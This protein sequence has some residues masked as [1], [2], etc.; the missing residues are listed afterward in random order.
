M[1]LENESKIK[2]KK[3]FFIENAIEKRDL[4]YHYE[5]IW[6]KRN[7]IWRISQQ[8]A[9]RF[10]NEETGLLEKKEMMLPFYLTGRWQK[11]YRDGYQ[12]VFLTNRIPS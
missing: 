12:A 8:K 10:P 5:L 11:R 9:R 7:D 2:D 4:Y 1:V 6:K 3:F